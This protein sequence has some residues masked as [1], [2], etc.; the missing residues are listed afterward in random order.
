VGRTGGVGQE[1]LMNQ[2]LVKG[3]GAALDPIG[4]QSR[5]LES[6]EH[7]REARAGENLKMEFKGTLQQAFRGGFI[8]EFFGWKVWVLK[9]EARGQKDWEKE[10]GKGVA[11]RWEQSSLDGF[12]PVG[13]RDRGALFDFV[14]STRKGDVTQLKTMKELTCSRQ[15]FWEPPGLG[16]LEKLCRRSLMARKGAL[17][18]GKKGSR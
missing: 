3:P 5:V 4:A 13:K 15:P 11:V 7:Q 14:F 1:D 2:I 12:K 6:R 9:E 10:R 18:R 16:Q 17:K 8:L